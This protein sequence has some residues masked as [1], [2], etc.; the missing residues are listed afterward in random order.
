MAEL[1]YNPVTRDWLMVAG[2]RQSRPQMPKDW[3]PFCVGSGGVP[4][5]G[6]DV[7]RYPNDFP[8]LSVHPPLPDGVSGGLF[9]AEPAYGRC[10]VLLYSPR[11]DARLADLE[12]AHIHKLA[13]LWKDVFIDFSADEQIKYI[14]IFENRG[15]IVGVTMPHPH[16]Q[17]YGYPFVP[18]NIREE[19]AGAREYHDREGCCLFCDLLKQELADGRRVIAENEHFA[20][21]VPFFAQ[22]AYMLH[23]TPKR[24]APDIAGLTGAE[25]DALGGMARDASAL[26]DALFD[27]PFPYMMCMHNAPVNTDDGDFFHFHIEFFTPLRSENQQQF[28]ASSETGAGAW[29]NPTCPEEKAAELRAVWQA[30]YCERS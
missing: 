5:G 28:M 9:T 25:L 18:R 15:A 26:Y 3:C 24:H 23:I 22:T 2:H 29:C 27:K 21:Y 11:H 12:D 16:G 1:R 6:Y 4:D 7:L 20:L 8:A 13:R 14:F 19:L 30:L 17:V 10:E